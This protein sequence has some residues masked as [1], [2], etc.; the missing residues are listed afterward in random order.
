MIA[1]L[2]ILLFRPPKQKSEEIKPIPKVFNLFVSRLKTLYQISWRKLLAKPITLCSLICLCFTSSSWSASAPAPVPAPAPDLVPAPTP[3]S[4]PDLVPA[5]APTPA[6]APDLVPAPAAAP[7][8]I[9]LWLQVLV[10][11]HPTTTPRQ[12]L[13]TEP[14]TDWLGLYGQ[15]KSM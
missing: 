9:Y 4:A 7:F 12:E 6:T 14:R 2:V 15:A 8:L 3:A 13:W 1:I 10:L 11:R 5:P